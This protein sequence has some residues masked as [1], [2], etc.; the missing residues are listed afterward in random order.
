ME[1]ISAFIANSFGDCVRVF[2][3]GRNKSELPYVDS[4]VLHSNVWHSVLILST[5]KQSAHKQFHSFV[6]ATANDL[7]VMLMS[8]LPF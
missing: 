5:V 7:I 2:V 4:T 3:L 8:N 6:H 1:W